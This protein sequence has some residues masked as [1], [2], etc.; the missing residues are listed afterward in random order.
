MALVAAVI[1]LALGYVMFTVW[2]FA[3]VSRQLG[4]I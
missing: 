3:D 2:L 4:G 1:I